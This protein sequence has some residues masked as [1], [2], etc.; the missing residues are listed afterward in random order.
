MINLKDTLIEN[1]IIAAIRSDQELEKALLSN[2]LVVFVL[3]GTISN[4]SDICCKL[5]AKDKI[6]FVH[7]DLIDGL[8]GNAAG[9]NFLKENSPFD[10]IITTKASN[11]KYAKQK[12]L[13]TIQRI[14]IID[15][16][17][18]QTGIKSICETNPTAV[19]IMPGVASKIIEDIK[20]KVKTPVVA[21]GLIRTKKDVIDS[22]SSGAIAIS[23]TTMDLWDI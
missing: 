14:F 12:G 15:T 11:I 21:G 5:K 2:T 7:L 9:I 19:E 17:S 23:T 4:I 8:K 6:V 18:L 13:C 3:Y 1:P 22:L 10:G 20:S 16:L